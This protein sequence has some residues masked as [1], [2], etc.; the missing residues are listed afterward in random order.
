MTFTK[1]ALVLSII[2]EVRKDDLTNQ[3]ISQELELD[4]DNKIK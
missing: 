2:D 3:L 1:G 4:E